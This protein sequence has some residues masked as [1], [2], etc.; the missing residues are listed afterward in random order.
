MQETDLS[1]PFFL[2]K[3]LEDV[4][5]QNVGTAQERGRK[6]LGTTSRTTRVTQGSGDDSD[7]EARRAACAGGAVCLRIRGKRGHLAVSVNHSENC[8]SE[9][10]KQLISLKKNFFSG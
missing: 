6:H 2:R 3:L 1:Y 9:T 8:A 7:G 4:I 10:T 5:Q